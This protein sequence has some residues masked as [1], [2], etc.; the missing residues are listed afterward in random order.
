MAERARKKRSTL[1]L[2]A[3]RTF[4]F[5]GLAIAGGAAFGVWRYNTPYENPLLDAAA[6]E[7]KAVFNPYVMIDEAGVTVIAPRAE[8]GQGIYTALAALVAEEMDLA[9]EDLTVIHG[10]AAS[11]Y[12]NEAIF[13]DG[14]PFDAADETTAAWAARG[15]A[16]F[17]AKSMAIQ[18][19]GG[20]TSVADA[21]DKMREAGAAARAGLIAAAA[22]E[23][24]A[25][26]ESLRAA[27]GFV[28]DPATDRRLAYTE[29]AADAARLTP[30]AATPKAKGD[31]TLLGKPLARVDMAEKSTGAGTF[32]VDVRPEGL[33][34][35]SAAFT[36]AIGV[37][38]TGYDASA[39]E[40]DPTVKAIIPLSEG[41]AV[42]AETTWAAMRAAEQVSVRHDPVSYT[43]DEA[44][45]DAALAAAFTPDKIGSNFRDDGDVDAALAEAG[46]RA[47]R[48]QYR[49][50]HLAHA[51][52][53]PMNATARFQNGKLEIWAG[54]QAPKL[55]PD[56]VAG[57]IGADE[58]EAH[59]T[60]LGGG[61][62]RRG[63]V[64][65]VQAAA[66]AAKGLSGALAGRPVQLVYSRDVDT[67]R[68][69]YRPP[70]LARMAAV[71]DEEGLPQALSVDI[72]TSSVIKSAISRYGVAGGGP[73]RILT[74]GAHDQPYAPAHFRVLGYDAGL[75]IPHGFWRSVGYSNSPFFLESFLDELSVDGGMD[76]VM[77]R[78]KLLEGD[79]SA[80]A[81]VQAAADLAGWSGRTY[82][83]ANGRKGGR[84][85]AYCRSFR[86]HVAMVLDVAEGEFG[87]AVEKAWIAA[88]VGLALDPGTIEAQLASGLIYGISA[89][90]RQE[91]TFADG[92]VEQ[93]NFDTFEPLRYSAS[94][95]IAVTILE[96][97]EVIGGVGEIA[98]PPAAPALANAVYAATGTRIRRLPMSREVDFA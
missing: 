94:P 34:F 49:T 70:A 38:M 74:D 32:G 20:S 39:I 44:E 65:Y 47:V 60:Y 53:E 43:K 58:V 15:V 4:M 5:G 87:L 54:M 80:Q 8:M 26:P 67:K 89:A 18:V 37:P 45:I 82:R 75:G 59:V 84:G 22:Q 30:S 23:W 96:S 62:G 66:E 25:A 42:V 63:E 78:L 72:A 41:V 83:G 2:I 13:E 9:L 40:G 57:R 92:A 85:L 86:S 11:A 28:I 21:F 95:E 98:T 48:A 36:P 76:P 64:D 16:G 51:C 71:L 19:T 50:P 14:L 79:P 93:A 46:P 91:I 61:F 55:V 12:F 31:W 33:L 3:R 73:D 77:M 27:G 35:A 56:I 88:D 90:I 97:G 6:A 69:A 1:G 10:P 24:G 52:M 17:M 7:G 81:T 29:I 68:D